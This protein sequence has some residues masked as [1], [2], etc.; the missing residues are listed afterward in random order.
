MPTARLKRQ[1]A[2]TAALPAWIE[3]QLTQLVKEAPD[4]AEWWHEIKFDG[5]RFM[6]GSTAAA[7]GC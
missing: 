7:S 3:P 5:F 6:P 2:H 4:G 1:T